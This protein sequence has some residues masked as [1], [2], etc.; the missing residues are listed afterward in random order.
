MSTTTT[1]GKSDEACQSQSKETVKDAGRTASPTCL[2]ACNSDLPDIIF[3]IDFAAQKHK[4]QRR[5]D[6]DKTPY[7]NHPIGVANI[8]IQEGGVE[9][10]EVIQAAVLHDTVEDTDT[11]FEELEEAF[12]KSVTNI[13]REVTDNKLLSKEERKELQIKN[14]SH[15]SHQAKLVKMAD[16]I[17]NLRDLNRALPEGWD[18]KRRHEYFVWAQKVCC[19]I[20]DANEALATCLQKLFT[21]FFGK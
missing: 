1:N 7:I 6:P 16:K 4:D 21:E 5:K 9:D 12:G 13:V 15:K 8:L 14:A 20:Y 17:Y 19:Q 2:S 10:L 3:T 11:T 18:E